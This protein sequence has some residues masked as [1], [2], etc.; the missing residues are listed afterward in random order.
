MSFEI[1]QLCVPSQNQALS[2]ARGRMVSRFVSFSSG[3][4]CPLLQIRGPEYIVNACWLE[5]SPV[6][7]E[8]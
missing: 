1:Y 2:D 8:Q 5:L 7:Q 3:C 4:L 6:S